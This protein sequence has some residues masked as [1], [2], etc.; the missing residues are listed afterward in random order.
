[1]EDVVIEASSKI[2]QGD[3]VR[4]GQEKQCR[5]ETLCKKIDVVLIVKRFVSSVRENRFRQRSFCVRVRKSPF[6]M[7]YLE[8]PERH[9][10]VVVRVWNI[11][12]RFACVVLLVNRM[13]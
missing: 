6:Y 7:R 5:F 12:T 3:S 1:M 9:K 2:D 4:L 13:K 11:A 8:M 10:N